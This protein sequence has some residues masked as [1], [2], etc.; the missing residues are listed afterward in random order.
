MVPLW[1]TFIILNF[2]KMLGYIDHTIFKFFLSILEWDVRYSFNSSKELGWNLASRT[3][4][5]S[6]MVYWSHAWPKKSLINIWHLDVNVPILE[7]CLGLR[8]DA[9]LRWDKK[10]GHAM[11][12]GYSYVVLERE[13]L[14]RGVFAYTPRKKKKKKIEE[15]LMATSGWGLIFLFLNWPYMLC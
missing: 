2:P 8:L 14:N 1:N 4:Y 7:I 12:I 10:L 3:Q 6:A 13:F 15:V 9:F 11:Y 5:L